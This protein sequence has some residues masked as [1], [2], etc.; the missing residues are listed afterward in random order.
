M[1]RIVGRKV[2]ASFGGGGVNKLMSPL[3]A[4]ETKCYRRLP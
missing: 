2:K 1:H 4:N 3:T